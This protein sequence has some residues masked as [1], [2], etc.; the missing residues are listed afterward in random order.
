MD[1]DVAEHLMKKCVVQLLQGKTRIL[2]THRLEFVE[3]ADTVVLME[4]G[5]IVRTGGKMLFQDV[6][7]RRMW[8]LVVERWYLE[9][10]EDDEEE[11]QHEDEFFL[12]VESQDE[13]IN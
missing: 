1:T 9:M 12:R 11:Q 8:V 5:T 10:Q 4:D 6:L 13:D 2:C 3:Q 7:R